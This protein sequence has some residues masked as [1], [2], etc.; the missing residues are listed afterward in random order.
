MTEEKKN[1]SVAV[2]ERRPLGLFEQMETEFDD[3]RRRMT[4][5]FHRPATRVFPRAITADWTWA[6]TADMYEQD[7]ALIVKAELPGVKQ[8]DVSVTIDAGMLRIAGERREEK[9]VK[10]A[11]YYATERF[12]GAFHRTIALPNGVDPAAI[13]AEFNDG[14]LEVRAPLP[15]EGKAEPVQVAV[16]G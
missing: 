4:D 9:E 16:K 2:A 5:L 10:E 3:L 14:V 15:A 1:G 8:E 6:P 11:K 13:T 7:G 12:T